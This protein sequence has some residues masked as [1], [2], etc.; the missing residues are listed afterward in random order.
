MRAQWWAPCLGVQ[1]PQLHS[2]PVGS[3][4]GACTH[5]APATDEGVDS[6]RLLDDQ[7]FDSLDRAALSPSELACSIT[8]TSFAGVGGHGGARGAVKPTW[9]RVLHLPCCSTHVAPPPCC[10]DDPAVYYVVG[11]ALVIPDEPEPTKVRVV[12]WLGASALASRTQVHVPRVRAWTC[13]LRAYSPASERYYCSLK[14]RG[15]S[16]C[17]K[18]WTPSCT[19]VWHRSLL[20]PCARVGVVPHSRPRCAQCTSVRRVARCTRA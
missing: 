5:P 10:I 19:W 11:T 3:Q 16:W 18:S 17:I 6:V 14:C 8:S 20:A 1:H 12:V 15:A 7:T 4:A 9:L 13:M 2:A